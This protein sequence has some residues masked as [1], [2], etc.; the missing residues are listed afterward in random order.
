V[1]ELVYFQSILQPTGP[2]YKV[3]KS[4]P[5]GWAL[6]QLP[7]SFQLAV[8]VIDYV[9]S[10]IPTWARAITGI[11]A[12]RYKKVETQY[13]GFNSYRSHA[14]AHLPTQG[15]HTCWGLKN[16]SFLIDLYFGINFALFR[17]V[18]QKKQYFCNLLGR[19]EL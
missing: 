6:N 17:L 14:F 13:N 5:L 19:Y 2:I 10:S 1:K 4:L 18:Q 12:R 9:E 15:W 8:H 7:M 11:Y 3:I 16:Q